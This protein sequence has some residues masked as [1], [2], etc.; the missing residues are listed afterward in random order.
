[1]RHERRSGS[2]YI[3]R[4][5]SLTVGEAERAGCARPSR[6]L[7]P[8]SY[9]GLSKEADQGRKKA[10]FVEGMRE[11]ERNLEAQAHD[12]RLQ[13]DAGRVRRGRGERPCRGER[14]PLIRCR[15]ECAL[16]GPSPRSRWRCFALL[17]S[18]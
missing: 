14:A 13:T 10:H 15:K 4:G 3:P 6:M 11:I 2:E 17:F 1:M 7:G 9:G 12:F 16:G 5:R 18:P 8:R